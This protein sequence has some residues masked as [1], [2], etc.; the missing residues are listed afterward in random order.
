MRSYYAYVL[1]LF[2][3]CSCNSRIPEPVDY[4]YSQQRKMQAAAHWEVL[5]ADLADRINNQ[6]IV[7]DNTHQAVFVKET[8]G[9]ESSSCKPGETSSFNEAFHDFLTTSLYGYGIPT[10]SKPDED[11]IEIS[12]KVQLVQYNA[13]RIRSLQPGL[14]TGLSAAITVLRDAPSALLFLAG[15]V[16]ADVANTSMVA[17]SKCEVIITTSMVTR[18]RYL[19]RSSDIYYINDED[20]FHYQ[21][22]ML[23][24]TT[25]KLSKKENHAPPQRTESTP[26]AMT[27]TLKVDANTISLLKTDG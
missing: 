10:K 16:T 9:D 5:A 12:Y 25:I 21:D 13:D 1:A 2:L 27:T 4:H 7:T 23:Q 3:V 8:C 24:S 20:F 11:A 17:S 14:L 18:G 19:F 15:G 22:N 26:E 6:L